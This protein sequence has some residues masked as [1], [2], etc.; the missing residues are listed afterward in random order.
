MGAKG[1]CSDCIFNLVWSFNVLRRDQSCC[2]DVVVRE[3]GLGGCDFYSIGFEVG[4]YGK[5]K[6]V[7]K[8]EFFNY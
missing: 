6:I 1:A 8:R 7:W 3:L 2:V 5:Y 4:F